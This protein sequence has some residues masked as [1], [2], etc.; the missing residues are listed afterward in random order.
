[1]PAARGIY[2]MA[3]D[4]VSEWLLALL[5]SLKILNGQ[6]PVR[7]IPFDS[8]VDIVRR[9]CL[10]FGYPLWEPAGLLT[11]CDQIGETVAPRDDSWTFGH[12]NFRRLAAFGG[13][14]DEFIYLD[15]DT[16]VLEPLTPVFEACARSGRHIV[17]GDTAGDFAYNPGA[18][19]DE[20]RADGAPEWNAGIYYSRAGAVGLDE[21]L[22]ASQLDLVADRAVIRRDAADQ[23]FLNWFA[24][25]RRLRCARLGNISEYGRC[26]AY[27]HRRATG[28]PGHLFDFAGPRAYTRPIPILHWAGQVAPAPDMPQARLWQSYYAAG[29]LICGPAVMDAAPD[30]AP[31]SGP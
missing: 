13:P 18:R 10:A 3:N 12:G 25:T 20:L 15:A 21:M 7:V 11:R 5:A 14:F 16:L 2:T 17:F 9:L 31:A 23:S 29:R 8:R 26:W 22:A 19:R 27:L 30:C 6:L 28:L 24:A 1:M 4:N